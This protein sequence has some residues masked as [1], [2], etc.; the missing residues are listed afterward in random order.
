MQVNPSFDIAPLNTSD[1]TKGI[2]EPIDIRVFQYY[3]DR[4]I[5]PYLLLQLF[6]DKI[7]D[8]SYDR[9]RA[10]I[11]AYYNLPCDDPGRNCGLISKETGERYF[12]AKIRDWIRPYLFLHAYKLLTPYGPP[13]TIASSG[14]EEPKL[15]DFP[16]VANSNLI[17]RPAAGGGYGQSGTGAYRFYTVSDNI[18]FCVA[19]D[20][21]AKPGQGA[22]SVTV[23][24]QDGSIEATQSYQVIRIARNTVGSTAATTSDSVDPSACIKKEVYADQEPSSQKSVSFTAIHFRSVD[25]MV[26]F[27]GRML[28]V[29]PQ[30]RPLKFDVSPDDA[31]SSRFTVNYLGQD[32]YIHGRERS[33]PDQTGCSGSSLA[34]PRC[35]DKT[36]EI[37]TLVT[38]LFNLN[39]NQKDL[40]STPAVQV[41][42]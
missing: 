15:K 25:G 39:K 21:N 9:Q 11:R 3:L 1:F 37:L 14:S 28:R 26:E 34:D 23:K 22:L 18:A 5:P 42:N 6:V 31:G 20:K 17:L 35:E 27:L 30:L 36:L 19:A 40:P 10:V 13:I 41:V 2:N 24:N 12:D 4:A 38:S 33:I 7:E 29:P 32:Y 16:G 8:V